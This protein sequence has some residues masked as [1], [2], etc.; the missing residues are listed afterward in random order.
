MKK[1]VFIGIIVILCLIAGVT[2]YILP[3]KEISLNNP[4][5]IKT[6]YTYKIDDKYFKVISMKDVGKCPKDTEC[7]WNGETVYELLVI[8]DEINKKTMST[9]TKRE[10]ET[11]TLSFKFNKNNKLIIKQK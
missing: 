1:L 2:V 5:T 6:N 3:V 8:D 4:V 9:I 11:K 7:I 10:I